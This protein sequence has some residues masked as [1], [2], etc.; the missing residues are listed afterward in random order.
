[1]VGRKVVN[2]REEEKL[3]KRIEETRPN[4]LIT[5]KG[6]DLH[7]YG[8][9]KAGLKKGS[10]RIRWYEKEYNRT[11]QSYHY[12]KKHPEASFYYKE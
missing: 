1:M 11:R 12:H 8:Y 5:H 9:I 2:I 4:T 7:K 3:I 10:G 6:L